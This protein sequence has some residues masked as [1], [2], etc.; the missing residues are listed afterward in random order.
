MR[1][2][3]KKAV[4][5]VVEDRVEVTASQFDTDGTLVYA[6]GLVEGDS[7]IYHVQIAPDIVVCDCEYGQH[8]SNGVHSHDQALRLAVQRQ[9]EERQ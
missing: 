5:L 4:R 7:G 9:R 6:T 3:D 8:T 1:P 2:V